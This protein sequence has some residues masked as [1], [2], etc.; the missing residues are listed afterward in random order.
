MADLLPPFTPNTYVPPRAKPMPPAQPDGL[1]L[2]STPFLPAVVP[3]Q[4]YM[5]W[6]WNG[7]PVSQHM[8]LPE[9]LQLYRNT[10]NR[11][12]T[13]APPIQRDTYNW[14][15][16]QGDAERA[17][18]QE[19]RTSWFPL[20]GPTG[21]A[22]RGSG[23]PR[24]PRTVGRQLPSGSNGAKGRTYSHLAKAVEDAR[25]G[26]M[27]GYVYDTTGQRV[28]G[29]LRD[30]P[31]GGGNY[32]LPKNDAQAYDMANAAAQQRANYVRQNTPNSVSGA[33][34]YRYGE[35]VG[36]N[37]NLTLGGKPYTPTSAA[38]AYAVANMQGQERTIPK[39]TTNSSGGST[40]TFQG[41]STGRTYT[42]G[43]LY[44][45]GNG[46]YKA[47]PNGTFQRV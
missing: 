41:S 38:D 26:P 22:Q 15:D 14:M 18:L 3:S 19:L 33:Y 28:P 1:L 30:I 31:T 40:T 36:Y 25:T 37:P 42:V 43:Q 35:K 34:Q 13:L 12:P 21:P 2:D 9:A 39:T 46:T 27:N 7:A 23:R 16:A 24:G 10:F 44:T 29:T 8:T 47:M 20:S 5:Q 32:L 6:N 11:M 17:R 4:N 45:T